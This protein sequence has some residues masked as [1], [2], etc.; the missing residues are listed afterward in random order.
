MMFRKPILDQLRAFHQ[1]PISKR[2]QI[3]ATYVYNQWFPG[4][5]AERRHM[6]WI[7]IK[8]KSSVLNPTQYINRIL[9]HNAMYMYI[10]DL[11]KSSVY[12]NITLLLAC[13]T[14]GWRSIKFKKGSNKFPY[15]PPPP[16]SV[17][18]SVRLSL[19]MAVSPCVCPSLPQ[20]VRLSLRLSISPSVCS[21]LPPLELFNIKS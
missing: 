6:S 8:W 3:F 15:L 10:R 12:L 20:S 9:Q 11:Q 5:I 7:F 2:V 14:T 4:I 17:Y 21:C 18:M 13:N 1:V 19:C 16:L